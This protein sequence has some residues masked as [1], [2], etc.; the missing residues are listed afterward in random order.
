MRK[1]ILLAALLLAIAALGAQNTLSLNGLN[2]AQYVYRTA[3]DS[4]NSYFRDSFGF[5]L[6][7]KGFSFGMKFIAELPKYTISQ[8]ELLDELASERLS[9]GWKELYASYAKDAYLIHAGTIEE[10]FGS[11]IVFRSYRDLE[12]D[13]DYR[14]TGF[15]FAYDD[16][17]RIKALYSGFPSPAA[18]GKYDLAYGA[19]A[20]YPVLEPLTLG[21]S[22]LA[23]QTLIGSSYKKDDIFAGRAKLRKGV[24]EINA[25]YAARDKNKSSDNGTAVYAN[26]LVALDAVQFGGAYKNY[27]DFAYYDHL[28]DLPLANYHNETLADSQPS[29]LD[30]EGF[31]GWATF[32]FLEDFSLNLDY[33]EAWDSNKDLKMNDA[34]AGLDWA[35][36]DLTATI[37]YN[38]VEKVDDGTSHWQKETYPSFNLGFPAWGKNVALSGEFKTVEKTVLDTDLNQYQDISHYE[39]KL[40]AEMALGKLGLSLGAQSWWKDLS[41]FADSRYWANLEATYPVLAGTDLI[42]FAGSEAGG[43]V[44]RNGVCRYVAPFSGL[45]LELNTRF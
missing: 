10:T 16:K 12:L 41:N 6:G 45:R 14:V 23:L 8:S 22:A 34:H 24:L 20:E 44:C 29:G 40:Q 43:K 38:H 2:E 9:L 36:N 1:L 7:Y 15:K 13:E 32:G 39:P 28:Q 33:A 30:E 35:K 18:V 42:F 25:E 17:L 27:D 37:S 26:A 19:D 11:G 3:Q 5:N 31:Q 21:A 4:L